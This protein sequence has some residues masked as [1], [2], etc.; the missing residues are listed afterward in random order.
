MHEKEIEKLQAEKEKVERQ[1][2]QEEHKIQ[3]LENRAAYYEKELLTRQNRAYRA[4]FELMR[5]SEQQ[6][7]SLRHDMK[8]HLA[9]LREYAA[10]GQLDKLEQYLHTFDQ[11]LT[12]PGFVHTGNPDVDSILNYKLGQAEAAGARL[13]LDVKLPE[14]FTADPFDLNV[15]LGNLLHNAVE[16]LTG[17]KDKRL[18]LSLQVDRGVFLLKIANSYDGVTLQTNGPEGPVYR[19]RKN[20]EGHGLGLSIVRRIVER[21]HG[22]LRIDSTGTVFT[23]E[24]ILYL[25]E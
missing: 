15:I 12:R 3:R 16:G 9:V 5:Q 24:T 25:E 18:S 11:K 6:I 13:E 17:S 4:E 2:A 21:Y 22:Q 20:G 23:V 8:N 19:S 14:G 10:Q 1:L 7:S